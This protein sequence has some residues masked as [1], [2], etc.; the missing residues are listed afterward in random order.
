MKSNHKTALLL[1]A[2]LFFIGGNMNSNKFL[3]YGVIGGNLQIKA[4]IKMVCYV[5]NKDNAK[6]SELLLAETI[7]IETRNGDARDYSENYGEGLT[8]FDRGT[9]NTI[10]NRFSLSKNFGIVEKIKKYLFTDITKINYED[11]RTNPLA[12]IIYA[13][14]L[15]LTVPAPIPK[16]FDGR[17]EYYK[18]YF[19]SYLGASTYQKYVSASKI[20]VFKEGGENVNV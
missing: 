12:S 5:I 8:Q 16:T 10:K 15:Y 9:F 14:L 6:E 18:K 1:G 4:Y 17:W 20:A 19:N 13:R 7:A 2:G 11:L 3:Y